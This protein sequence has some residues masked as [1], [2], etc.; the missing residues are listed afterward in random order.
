MVGWVGMCVGLDIFDEFI[1][2]IVDVFFK[3]FFLIMVR[4]NI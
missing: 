2:Y 4:L 3:F 1:N